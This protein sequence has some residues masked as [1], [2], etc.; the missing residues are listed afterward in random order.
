MQRLKGKIPDLVV[1]IMLLVVGVVGL[2]MAFDFPT[3]SGKWPIIIMSMLVFL[4]ALYLASFLYDL[5]PKTSPSKI[6]TIEDEAE[7]PSKLRIAINIGIIVGFIILAPF[8]GLFVSTA[9][10]LFIHMVFL[11]VRPIWLCAVCSLGSTG[12][13]YGFFGHL[14]GVYLPGALLF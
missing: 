1:S 3:K 6:A 14:L 10:Y 8:L 2:V 11:G 7:A 9:L 13:I 12:V 5:R 4:M